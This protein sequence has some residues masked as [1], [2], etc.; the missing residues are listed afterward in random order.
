VAGVGYPDK[1]FALYLSLSATLGRSASGS[2]R[3]DPGS[4]VCGT[5]LR[6]SL[7]VLFC[8]LSCSSRSREGGSKY[9]C[10]GRGS[11][12][13]VNKTILKFMM[14]TEK[15]IK[16][17]ET[18]MS[19]TR[20]AGD[21]VPVPSGSEA[22]PELCE[23]PSGGLT[24]SPPLDRAIAESESEIVVASRLNVEKRRSPR[25]NNLRV[26]AVVKIDKNIKVLPR[27]PPPLRVVDLD[28][29][30]FTE[31]APE[32]GLGPDLTEER[33]PVRTPLIEKD[34]TRPEDLAGD[35]MDVKGSS[36]EKVMQTPMG[37]VGELKGKRGHLPGSDSG[38]NGKAPSVRVQSI[39][40]MKRAKADL[41]DT[42]WELSQNPGKRGM[43]LKK[44]RIL[45]TRTELGLT[46][47][48]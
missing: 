37:E 11:G 12:T 48:Q 1:G 5:P 21:I 25:G 43:Y 22:R 35:K 26:V 27:P 39:R 31:S 34:T 28:S 10:S 17:P 29:P 20:Q 42:E 8:L 19:G 30:Y 2:R 40:K 24:A 33:N 32:M 45:A 13:L 7:F 9:L 44:P 18:R 16:L 23:G 3:I 36:V 15:E 46:T 41:D 38:F 47:K 14:S 4:V 6:S